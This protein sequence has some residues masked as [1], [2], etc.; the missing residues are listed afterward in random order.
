M[1][2]SGS[3][4]AEL[5]LFHQAGS[6]GAWLDVTTSVDTVA[7][8]ICGT[9]STFSPF[10]FGG[11]GTT[12]RFFAEGATGGLFDVRLAL[13][14]PYDI[15]CSARLKFLRRSGGPVVH[16]IDVPARSRRTIDARTVPGLSD[17]EFSTVIES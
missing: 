5:R 16:T 7:N 8:R 1:P 14:N 11:P 17:A 10:A 2:G 4:S 6:G 9:V 15:A 13:L 3:S 12:A